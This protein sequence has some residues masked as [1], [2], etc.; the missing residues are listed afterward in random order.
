MLKVKI[1][2]IM[3]ADIIMTETKVITLILIR[4][5][6]RLIQTTIEEETIAIRIGLEISLGIS[7]QVEIKID[8]SIT[9]I[10]TTDIPIRFKIEIIHMETMIEHDRRL[11]TDTMTMTKKIISAITMIMTEIIQVSLEEIIIIVEVATILT[12]TPILMIIIILE[13]RIRIKI[14]GTIILI[15]TTIEI[16]QVI[17]SETRII[18]IRVDI[19]ETTIIPIKETVTLTIILILIKETIVLEIIIK[20][21]QDQQIILEITIQVID[22]RIT[23]IKT[24]SEKILILEDILA[25]K[26]R[27]Q[28]LIKIKEGIILEQTIKITKIILTTKVQTISG[29]I[30]IQEDILEIKIKIRIIT[31]IIKI[32]LNSIT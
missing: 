15:T 4:A 14:R 29:I 22:S 31:R 11:I 13:I 2:I 3:M 20:I 21:I 7:I 16:N 23:L 30:L 32:S 19:P 26:T 12:I 1:E 5:E 24:I 27:I 9:M 10:T 17:T 25:N 8:I 28:I 6:G 18:R